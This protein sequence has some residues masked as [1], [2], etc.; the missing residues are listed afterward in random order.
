MPLLVL[1]VRVFIQGRRRQFVTTSLLIGVIAGMV[2]GLA[3]GTRRTS[4]APDRL[5]AR[6]G[7]DP[8]LVVTQLQG[9]PL[10]DSIATIPGVSEAGSWSF[11]AS[12]LISPTDGSP[13][14]EPNPFAGDDRLMGA[15]LVEGRFTDPA[16]PDEF[17]AN[18]AFAQL[19]A[20]RFGTKVGDVLQVASYDQTQLSDPTFNFEGAPAIAPFPV[21]FVGITRSPS[22]FDEPSHQLVFSQSFLTAHPTAGVVQT[23]TVVRVDPGTDRGA[24]IDAVR[25]LP[26]GEGA[27]N[28]PMRIVSAASRRAVQFQST[29][30]WLV[31]ATA[32]IAGGAVIALVV[33][34][35]LRVGDSER[36]SLTALGWRRRDIVVE[37]AIEG[38]VTAV[39]AIPVAVGVG[40]AV[41]AAF[42]LGVLRQFEPD[43]GLRTDWSITA[44]GILVMI[45]MVVA[46]SAIA[47]RR[48]SRVRPQNAGDRVT[49]FITSS[50][51]GMPLTAGM[52]LTT[53]GPTGARRS[54]GSLASVAV[55]FAG[56]VAAIIVGLSLTDI[57]ERP[58]RWGVNYDNLYGNPYVP[59][60]GDIT[61]P[62]VNDPNVAAL[63]AAT[64]GS[65]TIQGQDVATI[66]VDAVTGSLRPTALVGRAPIAAN[67][68]GLGAEVARRLHVG[69][70]DRVDAVG[71][72]GVTTDVEVVGIVVTPDS[73]GNGAAMTFDGFAALNP[74][75]TR[76]IALVTFGEDA[77]ANIAERIGDANFTPPDALT[78]P[79]SVRALQR[80]TA[81][82]FVLVA[83]L[84]TL[85][86]VAYAYLL[87]SSARAN[88][89]DL[90]V[91]RSLGADR[92][93]LRGVIHWH[94][95]L[96]AA[97]VVAMGVPL[98]VIMGR[99]VVRLV[100]TALGIVPGADVPVGLLLAVAGAALISANL[101]ALPSAVRA[102]RA[103]LRELVVDR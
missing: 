38:V 9:R 21:T 35:L 82:P 100:T 60:D 23:L 84:S 24:V 103:N 14:I 101:L 66:A 32:L 4:S 90:A 25:R 42:P 102:A 44:S 97:L 33:G 64:L 40:A 51:A 48:T 71:S 26:D 78:K 41:T 92:R 93:Q 81:A 46:I 65:V 89:R 36:T 63:T 75:A 30:L 87:S 22:E 16:A 19:L 59:N 73:A 88:R 11:V 49:R 17:T 28:A 15:T 86:L 52:H 1:R 50:G 27:F 98:G 56:L 58:D 13:V 67:E 96:S 77:P 8:D 47:G 61:A 72:S 34:R 5:T 6:A 99:W 45:A 10:T 53:N 80:V 31:T 12:F 94:A 3:A 74:T 20:D 55:G 2:L 69:V 76:N 57:V 83:V 68:I 91:L 29:S 37:R 85:L 39:V 62:F 43:T 18:R 7:G 54:L 79:T 70:G 95:T